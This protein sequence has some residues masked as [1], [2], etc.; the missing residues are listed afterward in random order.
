MSENFISI[1]CTTWVKH[2]FRM[3][4]H[5]LLTI[6][7]KN[8]CPFHLIELMLLSQVCRPPCVHMPYH[9]C[10][11][12]FYRIEIQALWWPLYNTDFVILRLLCNQS[13]S[14]FLV[15]IYCP[16]CAQNVTF[17]LMSWDVHSVLFFTYDAIFFVKGTSPAA[18]QSHNMIQFPFCFRCNFG[19]YA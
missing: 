13:D 7:G 6:L 3:S 5:K 1:F 8:V 2:F 15:I 14:L 10:P 17:W 18:K 4:F 9:I 11:Y 12:I 16:F 19:Q